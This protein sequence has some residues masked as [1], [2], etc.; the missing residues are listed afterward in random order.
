[1]SE[2]LDVRAD[3]SKFKQVLYN[4][5]S[6]AIKFTDQGGRVWIRAGEDGGMIEVEVGDT[7]VGIPKDKQARI[8]GE[9]YQ[10]ESATTRQVEGTGLGFSLTRRIVELHGGTIGWTARGRG[11]RVHHPLPRRHSTSTD[12]PHN[13]ILLVEDNPSNREL[14]TMVLTSNGYRGRYG[15]RWRRRFAQGAE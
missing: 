5:L 10:V 9:F 13:R 8:F 7:G 1:M 15:S 14:A 11:G 4:L 3:K 2:E 6:N 12:H